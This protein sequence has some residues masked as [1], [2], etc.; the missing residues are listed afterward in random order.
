MDYLDRLKQLGGGDGMLGA[1]IRI[2]G[3]QI[4]D[5]G[6]C[7][8]QAGFRHENYVHNL[9]IG[10]T[11]RSLCVGTHPGIDQ[12]LKRVEQLPR[13]GVALQSAL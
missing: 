12:F 7:L 11:A 5:E 4:T 9:R 2:D 3:V 6:G 13:S 8:I 10:T 1:L